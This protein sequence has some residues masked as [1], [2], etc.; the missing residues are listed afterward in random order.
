[1]LE[2]VESRGMGRKRKHV[3]NPIEFAIRNIGGT[4][5]EVAEKLGM[6]RQSLETAA[7]KGWL[8]PAQLTQAEI[9]LWVK[10]S[11]IDEG[12]LTSPPSKTASSPRAC[13][14]AV[15]KC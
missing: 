14:G 1:M 6:S 7:R 2:S 4:L 3:T 12:L 15:T 5:S 13:D 10:E 11:K 9:K 8:D